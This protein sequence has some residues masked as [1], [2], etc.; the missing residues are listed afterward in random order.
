MNSRLSKFKLFF[1]QIDT[2]TAENASVQSKVSVF[3]TFGINCFVE[4][5]SQMNFT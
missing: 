2:L 4:E 5:R 1:P 3:F